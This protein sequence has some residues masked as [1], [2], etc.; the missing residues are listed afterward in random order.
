MSF[1]VMHESAIGAFNITAIAGANYRDAQYL[2]E[3][4]GADA[5]VIPGVYTIGNKVGDAVTGMDHS[6][7]RSNSLYGNFSLGFKNMLYLDAS[8]RQDWS[9]T[10]RQAFFYPSVSL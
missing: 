2:Y 6:H 7:I 10:I 3:Q 4:I 9:S 8:A 5:L 1:T